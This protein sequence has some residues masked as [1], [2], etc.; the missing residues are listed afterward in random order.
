MKTKI[1]ALLMAAATCLTA[2]AQELRSVYFSQTSD[3]K[4]ELNP[5]LLDHGYV[6]MP[7]LPLGYFNLGTT[8][9]L[10]AADFIYKMKPGMQGYG[11]GRE[12]TTFMHPDVDRNEFL[13]HLRERNT[14]G[15]YLNYQLFGFAFKGFGGV[16]SVNLSLRSNTNACL[17]KDLFAFMKDTGCQDEYD[18]SNIGILSQTYAELGLGHAH[19]INDK[20]RIG[21]KVKFLF[22]LAYGHFKADDFHLQLTDDRWAVRG[23]ASLSVAALGAQFE[24]KEGKNYVDPATGITTDRRRIDGLDDDYKAQLGGF[25][26]AVDLGATYQLLPELKLSAAITDLGFIRW[27]D[28]QKASSKGEWTFD[29]F[30]NDIYVDG[31]DTGHNKIEDQLDDIGD[32]LENLFSVYEDGTGSSTKALAATLNIGADYTLPVYDKLHIGFLYISRIQGRYSWHQGMLSASVR[33][34]KPIE[35]TAN[36]AANSSG[37]T[38]GAVLDLHARHFNFFVGTDR[39]VGKLSKQGIPLHN[40][41]SNVTL[42]MSFPL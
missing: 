8:G 40:L 36:V 41:N 17:P 12:L 18:I 3:Y 26:M 25:G 5:A 15:L 23:N 14:L 22:G 19:Q 28:A 37:L 20:L 2:S 1:T 34:V 16:N 24:Y 11:N 10:G 42:G 29:G 27:R 32:D 39:F 6:A 9:N 30:K 35:I 21:A 31:T 7:L 33:P 4:H 13:S 38:Y